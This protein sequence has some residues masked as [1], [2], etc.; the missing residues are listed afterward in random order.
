MTA[1]LTA[2]TR[3]MRTALGFT[4]RH[5][6]RQPVVVCALVAAMVGSTLADVLMP[7]FAGRLVD[8]VAEAG[9]LSHDAARRDAVVALVAMAGLGAALVVLRFS[10]YLGMTRLTPRIMQDV[11]E[12]A[13]WR[14]QR[15]SSEWH[16][17]SFAG[18]VVR[19]ITRGAGAID[20]LNDTLLLELLPA[21][22]ALLGAA[23]VLGAQWPAMGAAVVAGAVFFVG[24]AVATSAWTGAAARLSNRWD[25]R[26]GGALADAVTCNAVVKAFGAEDREDARLAWVVGRW[27]SR[28]RRTW[29]RGTTA[30]L[31]QSITLLALRTAITGLG[32]WLWWTGRAGPGY[33]ATVLTMYFVVHGY[34]QDVGRQVRNVQRSAND[35]EEM[36]GLFGQPLGVEDRPGARAIQIEAGR[37][38]FERVGF[39]YGEHATPLFRDLC[40]TIPA[41]Q[42]AGLVGHSGS[43]KT[44]FV[45]LLQ[46]LHDV[47]GGRILVDG[48]DTAAVTQ[49]S[50]RAQVAIVP[51]EPAL[52]HRSLAENIAYARPGAT[53][54]EIEHAARLANAH[55]FI[56]ALP[57]GY[58]TLVGERGVKLSGGERQRVAIARAFLA[59]A[60]ILVLDEATA[61]LDSES[62]ALI[63]DAME[64]LMA[65][66]TAIVIAH[67]LSTVRALDRIL[68]FDAGRIVEEG[69]HAG[70]VGREGGIYR[71]LFERQALGL[72]AE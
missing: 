11:M 57:K 34:L 25:T 6:R 24:L 17:D 18:S 4:A 3:A 9:G 65:G 5:W 7:V 12:D 38:E 67:R 51:Q 53:R 72:L 43:G 46:R 14:V 48:Q 49:R 59:D 15:F 54:D 33:V 63:Q 60:P 35:M 29:L 20:L 31:V 26:L 64:R 56:S 52:F 28:L 30:N 13:F 27:R 2:G 45:K 16:A 19:Q 42:R 22:T 68:V 36:V 8:A 44:T 69:T 23:V 71:R 1:R 41:G 55:G 70:L 47:T 58:A 66:R 10:A 50:L 21:L 32:V 37:V 40:V 61:S 39:R 62:E